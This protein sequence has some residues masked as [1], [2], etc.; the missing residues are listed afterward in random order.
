MQRW[1]LIIALL[2][3]GTVALAWDRINV[4]FVRQPGTPYFVGRPEINIDAE[5]F[6]TLVLKI[7]SPQGGT[8]RLFWATDFDPRLNEPKSVWFFLKKSAEPQE[9][10]FNLRSQN[11]YWSGYVGQL[12]LLPENNADDCQV[13]PAW[14]TTNKLGTTLASGWQEFWGPRGRLVIGSTINT[15]QSPNLF[16]RPFLTY[17]Y[18]II[19]LLS[20]GILGWEAYKWN[21]LKKRP[22]FETVIATTGQA[23][24]IITVICWGVLEASSLISN[25]LDVQGHFK[26]VGRSYA[27]QLV[28][29][30]T[31]DFYPFIRFC[32]QTIPLRAGFDQRIPPIY[33]DI[34]ARYYLYPR[35]LSTVEADYLVVYDQ[36]VEPAVAGKYVPWK[37]FRPNAYI[38]RKKS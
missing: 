29:A 31:G 32:E 8:A 10:L 9:Y 35:Q 25:W 22:S 37:T 24:F 23:A 28:T 15:I 1:L 38:M 13:G 19:A 12:L 20:L 2:A 16:G 11:P 36:P 14:V 26:Y 17:I 7:S 5:E 6:Q 21:G 18:W 27:D 4:Q 3:A 30:N 33:N 34:K